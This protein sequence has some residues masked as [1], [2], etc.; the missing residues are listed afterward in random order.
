MS[1]GGH[2]SPPHPL[3]AR[4]GQ[5][6]W[7][8]TGR[9]RRPFV[10]RRVEGTHATGTRLEGQRDA[11]RVSLARLLETRADGQGRY[12]Q[13]QGFVSRRYVTWAYVARIDQ[14]HAVLYIPEW[15]PGRPVALRLSLLPREA[16]EPGTW[17]S[18]RCDLS[19]STPARLQPSHLGVTRDPGP[20]RL[21][22]PP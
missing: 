14:P 7:P 10:V 4:P 13:F 6:Y 5:R 1:D 15:H 18:L 21:R 17:L 11:V 3:T 2:G 19:A 12:Y 16:R 20:E 8:R 22:R 9:R